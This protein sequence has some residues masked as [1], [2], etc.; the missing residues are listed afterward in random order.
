M[1]LSGKFKDRKNVG[2]AAETALNKLILQP[3]GFALKKFRG[4]RIGR[5]AEGYIVDTDNKK[6]ALVEI[7]CITA[8]K[9]EL[10]KT[11]MRMVVNQII[12]KHGLKC[13]GYYNIK[14]KSFEVDKI[15]A[16]IKTTLCYAQKE[17]PIIATEQIEIEFHKVAR[18]HIWREGSSTFPME[19][20]NH[21]QKIERTISDAKKQLRQKLKGYQNEPKIIFLIIDAGEIN[22]QSIQDAIVGPWQT[23]FVG[24]TVLFNAPQGYKNPKR[25][26]FFDGEISGIIA[27]FP[28]LNN[29]FETFVMENG[30]ST[31]KIPKSLLSIFNIKTHQI[32][33]QKNTVQII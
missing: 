11:R 16:D 4:R 17:P 15:I 14:F 28:H 21:A 10:L 7:K 20:I 31:I 25:N 3:S 13:G 1:R 29:H 32:W 30:F 19:R 12:Q 26:R 5:H 18:K 27:L 24:S 22:A 9:T 8:P 6:I 2:L 23:T 33:Y